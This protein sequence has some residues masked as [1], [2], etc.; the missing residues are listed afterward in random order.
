MDHSNILLSIVIPVYN[1]VQ[2]I[3]IVVEDIRETLSNKINFEVVLVNDG[4]K[5]DSHEKCRELSRKYSF[6]KF[7]NLSKNFGQHN[8]ILAGLHFVKGDYIISMDD[9]LQTP[10][11]AIPKLINK[12]EEGYDVVYANYYYKC[13]NILR[14]IGSWT[15]DIMSY[16]LLKKP[17]NIKITNYFIIREYLIDEILNYT[18]P[19]PYLGGLI[20]RSTDNIAMIKIAHEKREYGKSSY[21]FISL[22]KLWVNGFTN[23]SVKPLR[24]SFFLGII[25]SFIGFL[26]SLFILIKKLMDP[27]IILGWTS[28]I[29][30]ILVFSGVQLISVGLIGEYIGRIFLVQNKQPQYIIKEKYNIDNAID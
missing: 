15:N 2:T 1:S 8:A 7:I 26:F 11:E 13:H 12:I 24:I 3:Q 5:D 6:V 18:G 29:I 21:G 10:P 17:K 28:I 23:F 4:S 22:L 14:K 9:D 30:A 20:L 16:F 19:Y 25:F 27:G